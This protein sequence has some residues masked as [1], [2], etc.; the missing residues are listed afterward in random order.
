MKLDNNYSVYVEIP[1]LNIQKALEAGVISGRSLN[2]QIVSYKDRPVGVV[3]NVQGTAVE[4]LITD[5][6]MAEKLR[7]SKSVSMEMSNKK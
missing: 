6:D 5:E 4:I 3:K 1:F 7:D 2:G